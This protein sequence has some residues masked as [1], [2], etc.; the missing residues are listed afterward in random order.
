MNHGSFIA[1]LKPLLRTWKPLRGS[2]RDLFSTQRQMHYPDAFRGAV[3]GAFVRAVLYFEI[4]LISD[5]E[6]PISFNCFVAV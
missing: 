3:L 4:C 1:G 5:S 2:D 6:K